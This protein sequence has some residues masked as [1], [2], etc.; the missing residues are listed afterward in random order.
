MSNGFNFNLSFLDENNTPKD[1]AEK[2]PFGGFL[3]IFPEDKLP[4]LYKEGYNRSV[5]GLAYQAIS[6]K[7]FYNLGGWTPGLMADIGSPI[8]SFVSSPGDIATM[9]LGGAVGKA[10]LKPLMGKTSKMLIRSGFTNKIAQEAAQ[11]GGEQVAKK[12]MNSSLKATLQVQAPALA[13]K[14]GT[15]IGALGFYSGLQSA[16]LQYIEDKDISG[17]KTLWDGTKGA[18]T[19]YAGSVGGIGLA[20]AITQKL[21]VKSDLVKL[22]AS[23]GVEV[24]AF[25]SSPAIFETIEGNP[26]FPHPMEYAHAAGVIGGL[27]IGTRA[28]GKVRRIIGEN[29]EVNPRLLKLRTETA[30]ARAKG[31]ESPV[32][33][34]AKDVGKFQTEIKNRAKRLEKEKLDDNTTEI[35]MLTPDWLDVQPTN[36]IRYEI[37]SSKNPKIQAEI[38]Q[39]KKNNLPVTREATKSQ[40]LQQFTNS[41]LDPTSTSGVSTT[42]SNYQRGKKIAKRLGLS[43]QETKSA[44]S[45]AFKEGDLTLASAR[46]FKRQ[47]EDR[48]LAK[49]EI[50][51]LKQDPIFE[52]QVAFSRHAGPLKTY[53][54]KPLYKFFIKG[55]SPGERRVNDPL[56][57][58]FFE[59]I[60]EY[61]VE[62]AIQH[63]FFLNSS[64]GILAEAGFHKAIKTKKGRAELDL[65]RN[66][67][68][69]EENFSNMNGGYGIEK[70]K[71]YTL[72]DGSKI[73]FKTID[74]NKYRLAFNE[75]FT[76][77]QRAG[78]DTAKFEKNYVPE[79]FKLEVIDLIRKNVE[80]M[81]KKLQA[82]PELLAAF[83][84]NKGTK[85]EYAA[86]VN[87][88]LK[89]YL[90]EIGVD[91]KFA[92]ILTALRKNVES[93]TDQQLKNGLKNEGS[94][95]STFKAFQI[96]TRESFAEL[97]KVNHALQTPRKEIKFLPPEIKNQ[98]IESNMGL[99][100]GRYFAKG[101]RSIAHS[102]HLG[103]K[104]EKLK[105][106]LTHLSNRGKEKDVRILNQL[107]QSAT[108]AIEWNPS[109]NWSVGTKNLLT[110]LTNFQVGTKIG[111]GFAV[112]PNIS[113][114]TIS[115]ALKTGY[116]PLINGFRNY[117][118]DKNYRKLFDSISYNYKDIFA[119]TFGFD[120]KT[121]E[122]IMSKFAQ[123]TTD[124]FFGIIP[125]FSFNKINEI[126]FKMTAIGSYEHL[127]NLQRTASGKNIKSRI[128]KERAKA[129]NEL[130]KAGFE[131][132]DKI[133]LDLKKGKVSPENYRKIQS[134]AFRF[135]RDYQLQKSV[136]RD[137]L[138]A[139]DPRFRPFFLF[140]RFGVRQAEL[141]TKI[142]SEEN[143]NPFMYLRLAAGGYA[144]AAVIAPA[145]EMLAEALSGTDIFNPNFSLKY[146]IPF[147][148]EGDSGRE[149]KD[150]GPKDVIDSF[151]TVGAMGIISDII[152]AEDKLRAIQFAVTP[153]IYQ[154]LNKI[155]DTVYKFS[156]EAFT[157]GDYGIFG[158]TKRLP[159]TISPVFGTGPRRLLQRLWTEKQKEDYTTYRKGPTRTRILDAL[160]EGKRT[161]AL[162]VLREWNRVYGYENPIVFSEIDYDDMTKRYIT[163]LEKRRRP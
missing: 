90:S 161:E 150:V 44:F 47:M 140:K 136:L 114:I 127:L 122:G 32:D 59:R 33:V 14:L 79:P 123:S 19:A 159:K 86:Q 23:K 134:Y 137:P 148:R 24:G 72:V 109:F 3:G 21:G 152:A 119:Q 43:E 116:A 85:G 143:S 37:V 156:S 2:Y 89:Q 67:L 142:L 96:L 45:L 160:L 29:L 8:I 121:R 158:A 104:D 75:L 92:K 135:A 146:E 56:K 11:E 7:E 40:V 93:R 80:D 60:E 73:N 20:P 9:A 53:L 63:N 48:L 94:Q 50:S 36:T 76:R 28:G 132:F 107:A 26:R 95:T 124:R 58:V 105:G 42:K 129:V 35:K 113:Q 157:P 82:D 106:I 52:K 41:N 22:M 141:F 69:S 5:E 30:E 65:L 97:N 103:A 12:A 4:N 145:R 110:D 139:N 78:I 16:S 83:Q 131:R 147:L 27:T 49:Q 46:R 102:K 111:L 101:S 162:E 149:L 155:Y 62:N 70:G 81:S 118:F 88:F 138:L 91:N 87:T 163:K 125:G 115:T 18:L 51:K 130:R 17:L 61:S 34:A 128:P 99:L 10:V 74:P 98:L 77:A 25:G 64:S 126:N 151:A 38:A 1:Y 154:D 13:E 153:V 117:H 66:V 144:G 57:N 112:I 71:T 100:T 120:T 54:P 15:N 68:K 133:N 84:S 55:L 39:A 6:G 108:G 31:V